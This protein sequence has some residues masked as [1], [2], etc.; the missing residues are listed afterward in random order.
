MHPQF[1]L[2]LLF[3]PL[4]VVFSQTK[5][6]IAKANIDYAQGDSLFAIDRHKS[7]MLHLSDAAVIFERN[8]NFDKL[9][10]CYTKIGRC[11]AAFYDYEHA[12]EFVDKALQLSKSNSNAPGEIYAYVTL[13]NIYLRVFDLNRAH[14][15][16]KVAIAMARQTGNKEFEAILYRDTGLALALEMKTAD[17]VNYVE[18]AISILNQLH[19][20]NYK[21]TALA[22]SYL[23]IVSTQAADYAGA[24]KNY[25]RALDIL[26]NAPVQNEYLLANVHSNIGVVHNL[27]GELDPALMNYEKSLKLNK[28]LFGENSPAVATIYKNLGGVYFNKG[29]NSKALEYMEKDLEVRK[30][31]SA[32]DQV[33]L[34]AAYNNVAGVYQNIGYF[35]L[36]LEYRLRC[37][38]I[39][40]KLY[41]KDHPMLVSDYTNIGRTYLNLENYEKALFHLQ[42]A[43]GLIK[44]HYDTRDK[45]PDLALVHLNMGTT[46][47]KMKDIATAIHHLRISI[48]Q[49]QELFG[50]N[51]YLLAWCYSELANCYKYQKQTDLA[52]KHL[53]KA[54]EIYEYNFGSKDYSI[55]SCLNR[56]A[57]LS[58][59]ENEH[60]KALQYVKESI[61]ANNAKLNGDFECLSQN[62]LISSLTIKASIHESLYLKKRDQ[63]QLDSALNIYDLCDK[64]ITT[65]RNMRK[66]QNDKMTFTK[67]ATIVYENAIKACFLKQKA[68]KDG[69]YLKKAFYYSERGKASILAGTISDLFAKKFASIPD[70]IIELENELK[71]ND[72]FFQSKVR[73]ALSNKEGYDTALVQV[74]TGKIFDLRR[75]SDSLILKIEKD[76]PEYYRVKFNHHVVEVDHLQTLLPKGSLLLEYFAGD[77][78]IYLFAVTANQYEVFSI[79][80]DDLFNKSIAEFRQHINSGGI[81][82]QLDESFSAFTTSAG[83]LYDILLKQALTAVSGNESINQLIIIPD[84]DLCYVPFD[85]FLTDMKSGVHGNYNAL[86]YLIKKYSI[87]YGYSATLNFI[88]Y[89]SRAQ[90]LNLLAFAPSYQQPDSVTS[91]VLGQFRDAVTPLR[92]NEEEVKSL[93]AKVGGNYY[94]SK[95]ATETRF[96]QDGPDYAIIHFAM[97]AL[98]DDEEP[99]NSRFIFSPGRDSAEDGYLHAFE[100]YNMELNAQ[101]AVL[102]ACN[103]GY[104]KLMK[105]EGIMSL[106][107]AFSYAG[108]PSVVMSHWKVDDKATSTI[109]QFF[110][111]NL[112]KGMPKSEALREAKLSYLANADPSELHPFYWAAF[113][114]TGDDSPL[115]FE[116]NYSS[117]VIA[118]SL[119]LI[120]SI[121]FYLYFRKRSL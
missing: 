22:Y 12:L 41:G 111:D 23:G 92:W 1:F 121:V 114:S 70:H 66:A 75:R 15:Y 93:A 71:T 112:V 100:L 33:N 65:M 63:A 74:Y 64:L 25:A 116:K 110:Y 118:S 120:F 76:F 61:L 104:G 34:R 105:G 62:V 14:E 30:K 7:A 107:R 79:P 109:M 27:L 52:G 81:K 11:K 102:S 16:F 53:K 106:A 68:N 108:V 98:V 28:S 96:K 67:N 24:K 39:M 78:V 99:M 85:V 21:E 72:S 46:Y 49:Y 19:G 31:G 26:N 50:Q 9:A 86:E 80:K 40:E 95:E 48:N 45:H 87:S 91:V 103:T 44:T 42:R 2:F 13:G 77:S 113:F 5:E 29:D 60:E 38:P 94:L 90:K 57:E 69:K 84:G 117:Y 97:H 54:I 51:Y 47:F 32:K 55:S 20:E 88:K 8:K 43:E 82:G 18:K 3:F 6:E 56:L 83:Y 36:E 101:I 37:I 17:A 58:L 35:H 10:D 119:F 59:I 4:S 115:I 73:N 89:N